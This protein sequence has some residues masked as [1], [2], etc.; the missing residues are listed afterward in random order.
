MLF[1]DSNKDQPP[2]EET[3]KN[4]QGVGRE[5]VGCDV[6]KKTSKERTIKKEEVINYVKS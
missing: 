2:A 6:F 1:T 5:P 4:G 3:K